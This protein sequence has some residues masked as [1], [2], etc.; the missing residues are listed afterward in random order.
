[1]G[2]YDEGAKLLKSGYGALSKLVERFNNLRS[3]DVRELTESEKIAQYVLDLL[4]SG[5]A[6]EVTDEMLELAD[7]VYLYKNYDLPM[8]KASRVA[9]ADEIF[10]RKGFH[11]ANADIDAFQGNVFSTDNPTL[12]STY[13]RGS[14]DAQIYP[15][16]LGSKLGDAVV[17]G[18]GKNWNQFD[19]D[20]LYESN[21]E[22]APYVNYGHGSLGETSMS[23]S[24]REIEKAAKSAGL[25]GVQFK[26]INDIGPGFN[27]TQ[28]KN[29]GYT[30]EQERALQRQY[31]KDLSEPSN[32]DVRLSPNL[33]RSIFARFDPR[34]KHLQNLSAA[35]A[36]VAT[37]GALSQIKGR[38]E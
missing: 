36:P 28:F 12:A 7:D 15:L 4:K 38:P 26:N 16:R 21:P 9:R 5:R 2:K 17:E 6:D 23:A 33:V 34:L 14:K 1:M 35:V 37:A 25:S 29:L 11:G 8:D 20:E 27:S 18:K 31:M 30:K 3:G 10:P 13:A 24:T 22:L 32:V 19:I